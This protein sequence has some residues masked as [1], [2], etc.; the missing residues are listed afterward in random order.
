MQVNGT[1]FRS[2]WLAADRSEVLVIDQTLL[3]FAFE[4][5]TL[6]T[7]SETALAI[8]EMVVRGAPLIGATAACGLFLAAVSDAS[9]ANLRR[10]YQELL[11]SR[12]TAVN[13][14]WALERVRNLVITLPPEQ[15]AE[16]AK[17]EAARIADED[18]AMCAAI[19]DHGLEIFQRLAG[20]R[21]P[22]RQG[23]ARY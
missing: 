2:I 21:S 11:S 4:V 19:G 13:L 12:P 3:P 20:S 18:V 8:R 16:A 22:K 15:R 17:A 10:A 23:P 5:R 9:E 7:S 6:T 14:R 1:P